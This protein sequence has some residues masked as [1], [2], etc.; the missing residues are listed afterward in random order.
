MIEEAPPPPLQIP[1]NPYLALLVLKTLSKDKTILAPDIPMGWP[2]ATAPP[3]TLTLS[4]SKSNN[5]KLAK[6]VAA[7]ASLY[8]W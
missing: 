7:K 6:A 2:K 4:M 5:F 8:S 3:C 1:A